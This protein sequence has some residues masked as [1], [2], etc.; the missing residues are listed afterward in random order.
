MIPLIILKK[1]TYHIYNSDIEVN[2]DN[3]SNKYEYIFS[4]KEE[5]EEDI[6]KKKGRY[7]L[8]SAIIFFV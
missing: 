7:I 5:F 6:S 4:T 2:K 1:R 3:N 8:L